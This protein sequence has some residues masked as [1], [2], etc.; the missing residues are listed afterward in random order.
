M[1]NSWILLCKL[2]QVC[3][4]NLIC[5]SQMVNIAMIYLPVVLSYNLYTFL[6]SIHCWMTYPVVVFDQRLLSCFFF[7]QQMLKELIMTWLYP[8]K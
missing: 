3:W 4:G 5:E 8:L 6:L 2:S 7:I 1:I